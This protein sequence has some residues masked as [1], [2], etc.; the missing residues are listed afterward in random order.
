MSLAE[1]HTHETPPA[2][3]LRV[4]FSR[5]FHGLRYFTHISVA[6]GP[7]WRDTLP[8]RLSFLLGAALAV[9]LCTS[10]A[11]SR[12]AKRPTVYRGG[13]YYGD[14]LHAKDLATNDDHSQQGV[15]N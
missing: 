12:E 10:C 9:F 5:P 6:A 4:R 14:A 8:M 13:Q 1:S 3:Q 2:L 15:R 11:S 7:W